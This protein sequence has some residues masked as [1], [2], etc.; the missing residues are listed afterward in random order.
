MNAAILICVGVSLACLALLWWA[1]A[2]KPLFTDDEI[3]DLDAWLDQ[4]R[5]DAD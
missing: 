2:T 5:R 1:F 3:A 4:Q